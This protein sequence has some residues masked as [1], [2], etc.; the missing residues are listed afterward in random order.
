MREFDYIKFKNDILQ[1]VQFVFVFNNCDSISNE[2]KNKFADYLCNNDYEV[3]DADI[4]ICSKK[5]IHVIL[6]TSILIISVSKSDYKSR[7]D[8]EPELSY[9]ITGLKELNVTEFN[10]I[11]CSKTNQIEF[12]RQDLE[13]TKLTQEEL[14]KLFFSEEYLTLGDKDDEIN[15]IKISTKKIIERT[16]QSIIHN[17][18]IITLSNVLCKVDEYKSI[19]D[20][21]HTNIYNKF[22]TCISDYLCNLMKGE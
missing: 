7:K 1:V 4:L 6:H 5:S 19:V 2:D 11:L 21:C 14:E 22:R 10:S 9:I 15:G 16:D 20:M 17:L 12:L 3:K 8:F 13:K 18:H